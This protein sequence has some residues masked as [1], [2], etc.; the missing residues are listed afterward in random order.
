MISN[1]QIFYNYNSD[2]IN[3]MINIIFN[4]STGHKIVLVVNRDIL[5]EDLIIKYF[6]KVKKI[7]KSFNSE[8][9]E[10]VFNG[11]IIN[12]YLDKNLILNEIGIRDR[13]AS[14]TVWDI[15]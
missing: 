7:Y 5:V 4:Q 8:N 2:D 13:T 10:F 9:L 15:N 1:D 12:Y 3:N 14:I 6:K 11:N